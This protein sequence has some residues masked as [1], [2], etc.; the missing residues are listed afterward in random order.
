MLILLDLDGTLINTVHPTWKPYKD[1]KENYSINRILEKIP[2]FPGV[3][4]FIISRKTKN[5]NLVIVSDS[6]HKYVEPISRMLNL[7]YVSLADKP[8]TNKIKAFLEKHPLYKTQVEQGDCFFI[9]DTKLDIELGRKLGVKTIWIRPYIVTEEIKDER[10]GVGC[11]VSSIKLGPTYSAIT[12][13]EIEYILDKPLENLYSIES[14]F[15]GF[16]STNAINYSTN[17]YQDGTYACIRC[18]ARQEQGMCDKYGCCDK[19]HL[20]SNTNRTYDLL[21]TLAKGISSFINQESV[22]NQ[23]WDYFT[24]LLDKRSTVPEN[25]LKEIFDIVE[26]D[27][28]KI[29][30]LKWKDDVDGS[31]RNKNLY[32]DRQKFLEEYLL[33]DCPNEIDGVENK[34]PLKGLNIIVLDDQLTTSATAW[35]VI[36]ELKKK[37]AKNIMFIA[38]FQIT[39]PVDSDVF[40]PK[41]RK[42]MLL[43]IRR[44]DG[45]KFYSC[46]PPEF[47]GDG[48]GYIINISNQ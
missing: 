34:Y 16:K 13:Q 37:G 26:T 28:K 44:Y 3:K 23:R 21:Q 2:I 40:C 24:Y 18:L 11:E 15:A 41:C 32:K 43:K 46:V 39:L 42:A 36:R 22:K 35:Y 20:M 48:C 12:F 14:A 29:Q 9:G 27:I 1:A 17:Y 8:N 45:Q 31:L 4:E 7:E 30:L 5:D 33:L 47:G 38:M 25:K 10:D 6:H 19:Y